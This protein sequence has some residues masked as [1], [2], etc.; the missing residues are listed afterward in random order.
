VTAGPLNV[1]LTIS[2]A[3]SA[4][5]SS[6]DHPAPVLRQP[7]RAPPRFPS[8]FQLTWREILMAS[9]GANPSACNVPIRGIGP[10][11]S[12]S[13]ITMLR[14]PSRSQANRSWLGN[15]ADGS[16]QH[17]IRHDS[18]R[19]LQRWRRAC[20]R[21]TPPCRQILGH[22]PPST[23]WLMVSPRKRLIIECLPQCTVPGTNTC[24]RI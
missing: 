23:D 6:G 1:H 5:S 12:S 11:T 2:P 7:P 10:A 14:N 9:M 21:P 4:H 13:S 17:V 8:A 22:W 18:R 20:Q 19:S 16:L 24:Q 15:P 3:L